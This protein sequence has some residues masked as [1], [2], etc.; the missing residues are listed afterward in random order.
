MDETLDESPESLRCPPGMILATPD[1]PLFSKTPSPAGAPAPSTQE[2]SYTGYPSGAQE[3]PGEFAWRN[4]ALTGI[5]IRWA[6][7]RLRV[8]D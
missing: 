1:H 2:Y 5:R 3:S 8:F 4:S 7:K 6:V